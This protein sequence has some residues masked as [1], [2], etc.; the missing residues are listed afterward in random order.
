MNPNNYRKKSYKYKIVKL[1]RRLAFH[2]RKIK[3]YE[4]DLYIAKSNYA[5]LFKNN[6]KIPKHPFWSHI[7]K[8]YKS[9]DIIIGNL[10]DES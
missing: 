5:N 3:D 6:N 8:K 4:R 1:M 7:V 2:K 10:F 9:N